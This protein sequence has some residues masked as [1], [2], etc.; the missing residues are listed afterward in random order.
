MKLS[1][2]MIV[3]RLSPILDIKP[4]IKSNGHQ[5][6]NS[7]RL[8]YATNCVHVYQNQGCVVYENEGDKIRVYGLSVKEAFEILQGV[9]DYFQDWESQIVHDIR[10]R[11]F[12]DLIE[13]CWLMFQNPMLIQNANNQV[14]AITSHDDLG[15]MDPEWEY[16]KKYGYSSLASVSYMMRDH[17]VN[18]SRPGC[19]AYKFKENSNMSYGGVSYTMEFGGIYCGRIT[20]LEK[21]RQLNTGDIQLLKIIAEYLQPVLGIT[22]PTS[23]TGYNIFYDLIMGNNYN[24]KEMQFQLQYRHWTMEDPYQLVL[25]RPTDDRDLNVMLPLLARTLSTQLSD[26]VIIP[27]DE[28][29]IILSNKDLSKDVYFESLLTPLCMRSQVK[30]GYSMVETGPNHAAVLY[31]QALAALKYGNLLD[32][33]KYFYLFSDYSIYFILEN[34]SMNDKFYACHPVIRKLWKQKKEQNDE[35]YDTLKAY[36]DNEQSLSKTATAVFTHRNTVLYRIKK[37]NEYLNDT[38]EAPAI[39]YYLRLS[40][41]IVEYADMLE[42]KNID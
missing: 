20:I 29:V 42:N 17:S 6:L 32:S 4:E 40:M 13:H 25:L 31:R 7:A 23:P 19:Q 1:M 39:R 37:C 5:V 16:L 35:L 28:Y 3:N 15:I 18:F 14:L 33:E 26:A 21:N 10:K 41:H 9:F 38:L 36:L 34:G 11:N 30:A 22:S 2:W 24:E 12:N 27:K 8:A